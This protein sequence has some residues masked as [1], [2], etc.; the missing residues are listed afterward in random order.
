MANPPVPTLLVRPGPSALAPGLP[1]R[2]SSSRKTA[3]CVLLWEWNSY[4]KPT[5]L[6]RRVRLGPHSLSMRVVL[7]NINFTFCPVT[8]LR[9]DPETV[10]PPPSEEV[11]A[12][13]QHWDS[14][15]ANASSKIH[16]VRRDLPRSR[17]EPVTA[18]FGCSL[19][20]IVCL[21]N[22]S[23]VVMKTTS[24]IATRARIDKLPPARTLGVLTHP[25]LLPTSEEHSEETTVV[26]ARCEKLKCH[27]G[28]IPRGETTLGSR[29][30]LLWL[31]GATSAMCHPAPLP[32]GCP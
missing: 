8:L 26:P 9:R 21:P 31:D 29:S 11:R 27:L 13:F 5:L 24:N 14:L 7:P 20:G 18:S 17:A 2:P 22:S 3:S 15:S 23:V 1:L 4:L 28:A 19:A 10:A 12:T 16:V 32:W 25:L 6:S 30:V